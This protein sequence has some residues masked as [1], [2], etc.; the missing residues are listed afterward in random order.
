[1]VF[2]KK[3][4]VV[5]CKK[6]FHSG[7]SSYEGLALATPTKSLVYIRKIDA[8]IYVNANSQDL[9]RLWPHRTYSQNRTDEI[10]EPLIS[11]ELNR[12]EFRN[13]YGKWIKVYGRTYPFRDLL[14][15]DTF[16]IPEEFDELD[17][18]FNN[19]PFKL[20]AKTGRKKYNLCLPEE[21]DRI[22]LGEEFNILEDTPVTYYKKREK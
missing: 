13:E 20:Y 18:A 11:D 16:V 14:R 8:S 1:M 15:F 22:G 9:I 21:G 4:E 2:L 17:V 12:R 7:W 5:I 10:T 3:D 6:P 19:A